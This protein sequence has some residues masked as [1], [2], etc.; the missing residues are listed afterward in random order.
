MRERY[1]YDGSFEGYLC[2]LSRSLSE[3]AESPEFLRETSPER[4]LFREPAVDVETDR[5]RADAFHVQFSAAVS[6]S[7]FRTLCYA[8]ACE[9]EEIERLLWEYVRLGI[10]TGRRLTSMLAD[11]RVN[12]VNRLARRV[13]TEAHRYKGF[14]RFRE[15]E[16]GFLYATIEP[17]AHIIRFLAPHFARRVGD[18]PWIL[19]DLRRS[20]A[21]AYDGKTWRLLLPITLTEPPRLSAAERECADLWQRYFRRL[22]IESRSNP[23]LQLNRV[24]LRCRRHLL[25]FDES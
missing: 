14:V 8:F 24:P 17:K 5:D 21:A 25:E 7:A 18:R 20:C 2:A 15:V 4:G 6:A 1:R 3:G 19:H 10:E 22:A 9:Q 23:K 13:A 11:T 16:E 12:T